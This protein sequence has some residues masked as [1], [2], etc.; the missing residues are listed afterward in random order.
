MSIAFTSSSQAEP[1]AAEILQRL[2]IITPFMEGTDDRPIRDLR[3]ARI[4]D[5]LI[6]AWIVPVDAAAGDLARGGAHA[7]RSRRRGD[8][9]SRH[10]AFTDDE[11]ALAIPGHAIFRDDG[12]HAIGRTAIAINHEIAAILE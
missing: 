9:R 4:A 12:A 1:R 6:D 3:N 10:T 11:L 5:M 7:A 8:A 2:R